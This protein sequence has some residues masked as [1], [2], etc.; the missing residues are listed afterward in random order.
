MRAGFRPVRPTRS[1]AASARRRSRCVSYVSSVEG[2]RLEDSLERQGGPFARLANGILGNRGEEVEDDLVAGHEDRS[3][4]LDESALG[5]QLFTGR[6]RAP[7]RR[8]DVVGPDPR[9]VAL[10]EVRPFPPYHAAEAT[11]GQG[12]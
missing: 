5:P 2:D 6:D 3:L 4:V 1:Q 10:D 8:L 7:C 12:A 9:R 11:N